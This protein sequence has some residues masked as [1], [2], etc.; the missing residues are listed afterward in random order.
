MMNECVSGL[1]ADPGIQQV[2]EQILG[3][4]RYCVVIQE[5]NELRQEDRGFIL[6]VKLTLSP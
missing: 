6:R 4:S 1:R 3:Y 5:Y 2:L